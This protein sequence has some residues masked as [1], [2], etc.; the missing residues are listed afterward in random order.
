MRGLE[1]GQL[2]AG[3]RGVVQGR[4]GSVFSSRELGQLNV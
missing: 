1:K 4:N 3:V 2:L